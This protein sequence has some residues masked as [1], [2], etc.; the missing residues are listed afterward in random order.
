MGPTLR[1]QA[2]DIT[3]EWLTDVLRGSGSITDSWIESFETTPVGTGQMADSV[4]L[5]LAYD[6]EEPG[7][8]ASVVVK[9]A[10][11][12]DTSRATGVRPW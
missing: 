11:A 10:A 1:R 7:A 2:A 8:P 3:I 6:T 9:L 4:R 12:D 5:T